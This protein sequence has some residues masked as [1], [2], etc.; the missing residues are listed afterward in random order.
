ME[1]QRN[2]FLKEKAGDESEFSEKIGLVNDRKSMT[3]SRADEWA[4]TAAVA[5][6]EV[7]HALT[8]SG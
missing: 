5:R 3:G 8:N 6:G 2:N 4:L 7:V 1:E